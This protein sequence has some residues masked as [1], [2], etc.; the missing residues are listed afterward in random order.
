MCSY[1]HSI[2]R[3]WHNGII[4]LRFYGSRKSPREY[5]TPGKKP[6]KEYQ[7]EWS[8]L[9]NI[10]TFALLYLQVERISKI[11]VIIG[12]PWI[13]YIYPTTFTHIVAHSL[14]PRLHLGCPQVFPYIG[15]FVSVNIQVI[16]NFWQCLFDRQAC[17]WWINMH[18]FFCKCYHLFIFPRPIWNKN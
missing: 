18:C 15:T 8:L 12:R 14:F 1:I 7:L 17:P 10:I 9:K 6:H 3:Y 4:W 11:T 13:C 16:T 2:G 5:N